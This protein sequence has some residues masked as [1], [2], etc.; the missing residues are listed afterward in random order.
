M[1][2]ITR[3]ALN[4]SLLLADPETN[5]LGG[6]DPN[7]EIPEVTVCGLRLFV[8]TP[9]YNEAEAHTRRPLPDD[10]CVKC[11]LGWDGAHETGKMPPYVPA[12]PEARP[13]VDE[14]AD[15]PEN[16]SDPWP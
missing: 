9:G 1:K 12:T 15:T 7:R 10:L 11:R 5:W 16:G 8:Y 13:R 6:E 2:C 14:Q 4:Y 3:R